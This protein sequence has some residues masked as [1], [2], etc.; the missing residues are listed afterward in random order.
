M[1]KFKTLI[2][3]QGSGSKDDKSPTDEVA[4]TPSPIEPIRYKNEQREFSNDPA[5]E[6]EIIES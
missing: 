6:A 2:T 5:A 1:R 3:R 4:R